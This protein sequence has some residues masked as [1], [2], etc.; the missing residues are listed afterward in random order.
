MLL[1]GLKMFQR[2]TIGQ[3][4][5]WLRWRSRRDLPTFRTLPSRFSASTRGSVHPN[6]GLWACVLRQFHVAASVFL[7]MAAEAAYVVFGCSITVIPDHCRWPT[8]YHMDASPNYLPDP[9]RRQG[10]G[11]HIA[12]VR[13]SLAAR[14]RYQ[15]GILDLDCQCNLVTGRIRLG[16]RHPTFIGVGV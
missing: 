14:N 3:L 1:V 12:G 7:T 10:L 15:V 4:G 13:P 16:C 9:C 2:P 6:P 5:K 11:L 8:V